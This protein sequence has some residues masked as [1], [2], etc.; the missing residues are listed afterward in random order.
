MQVC[1]EQ[2]DR[3]IKESLILQDRLQ[4]AMKLDPYDLSTKI[5]ASKVICSV[6]FEHGQSI[7]VL[8]G[9]SKFTSAMGLLRLQYESL[10]RSMWLLYVA[11]ETDVAIFTAELTD[12]ND[13]KAGKLPML[14]EMLRQM[15][16]NDTVKE[17]IR[18]LLELKESSLKPLNSYIHSGLHV[19]IRNTEGYPLAILIQA[20]KVS[21]G[22]LMMASRMFVILS[23]QRLLQGKFREIEQ[24]FSDSLPMQSSI[25]LG[26]GG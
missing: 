5:T 13:K 4:W 22:L 8:I 19:A 10:V 15:E 6:S 2:L 23:G 7:N 21:N 14:S 11:S 18:L 12:E 26:K 9:V 3:I 25:I 1:L 16:G 24:Q 20:L 17:P